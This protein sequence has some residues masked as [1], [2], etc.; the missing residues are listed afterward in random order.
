[1]VGCHTTGLSLDSLPS[2]SNFTQY[3]LRT[4]HTTGLSLDSLPSQPNLCSQFSQS[5]IQV[6]PW[7][8]SITQLTQDQLT[9]TTLPTKANWEEASA[10]TS[11]DLTGTDQG[12]FHL[13]QSSNLR[14]QGSISTQPSQDQ[15]T[16]L[17]DQGLTST[18]PSQDQPSQL[19]DQALTST[20][21][22]ELNQPLT[23]DSG[24]DHTTQM[25]AQSSQDNKVSISTQL[26]EPNQPPTKASV[27]DHTT[28][29]RSK[30]DN[31]STSTLPTEQPP[32]SNQ[33]FIRPSP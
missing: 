14:D 4:S 16:Q 9:Q 7:C 15:S 11:E 23:K 5:I 20:Q 17:R 3:H 10:H 27:T 22:A 28:H 31:H 18:H 12:Q 1:M 25:P 21:G 8:H 13:N 19:R 2:L 33:D 24:T 30:Q 26:T 6:S 32:N 29:N